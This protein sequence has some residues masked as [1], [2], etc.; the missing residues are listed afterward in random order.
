[1]YPGN[2]ENE[3][4]YSDFGREDKVDND[5]MSADEEAFLSGYD[6][7]RTKGN[8]S[9]DS[10]G[11]VEEEYEKAFAKKKRRRSKRQSQSFDKKE[12]E[13]EVTLQ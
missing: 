9:G 11:S 7:D 6:E 4:V 8:S 5:E 1:M 2:D 3:E 12:I 13:A 10:A